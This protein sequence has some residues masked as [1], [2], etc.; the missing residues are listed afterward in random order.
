MIFVSM[1]Q[2][3]DIKPAP[4]P[5]SKKTVTK[6]KSEPKPIVKKETPKLKNYGI[7]AEFHFH[8]SSQNP[9]LPSGKYLMQGFYDSRDGSLKLGGVSWI[10]RPNGYDMVP[11]S[12][13]VSSGYDSF[14]GRIE[15]PGCKTFTLRKVVKSQGDNPIAG[16]WKGEYDCSQGA[17]GL[18]LTVK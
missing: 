9:N 12:G 5:V 11:L 16:Q 10:K 17:T 4:K 6:V 8:A 1:I 15:F 2:Q 7:Y 18:T 3:K 13:Q 14:T